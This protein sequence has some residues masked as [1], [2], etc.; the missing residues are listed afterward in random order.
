MTSCDERTAE[1]PA[2]PL[3]RLNFGHFS[4]WK[5]LASTYPIELRLTPERIDFQQPTTRHG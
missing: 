5:T 4:N 1:R 3:G 2:E